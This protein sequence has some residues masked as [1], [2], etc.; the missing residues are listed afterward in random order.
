MNQEGHGRKQP[1][2][3]LRYYPGVCHKELRKIKIL[4]EFEVW[5]FQ[6]TD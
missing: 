1:C 5:T 4:S 2:H 6:M 3:V